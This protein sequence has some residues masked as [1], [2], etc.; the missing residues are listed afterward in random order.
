VA[1]LDDDD[2]WLPTMLE[3]QLTRLAEAPEASAVYCLTAVRIAS[4]LVP[5][6]FEPPLPEGD[7]LDATLT[8]Q[9]PLS[10]CARVIRRSA[11]FAVG[12]FDEALRA[13]ED[14]DLWLRLSVAGYRTVA[15]GETLVITHAE[16]KR[17]L[18]QD[19]ARLTLGFAEYERRWGPLAKQRLTPAEYSDIS[20]RHRR[21][22]EPLH[23]THVKRLARKGNR[24]KARQYVRQMLPALP[25]FP[26]VIPYVARASL[27]ALLGEHALGLPGMPRP[28]AQDKTKDSVDA[29]RVVDEPT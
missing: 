24:K 21:E 25:R 8:L 29:A 9:Y 15:V 12:G 28:K 5:S 2:E 26:W 11:L 1:F 17:R 18:T 19:A 23:E 10:P 3:A 14:S 6:P 27:V 22:L 16:H 20:A 7:L 4:A 13:G